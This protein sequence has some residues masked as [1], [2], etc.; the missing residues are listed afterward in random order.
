MNVGGAVV[1]AQEKSDGPVGATVSYALSAAGTVEFSVERKIAGRKVGQTLR[2]EDA[3]PTRPTRNAPLYKKIKGSFSVTGAAGQNSFKFSGRIG[4]K[5]L[6]PGSYRLTGAAGGATKTAASRSS[7]EAS[8]LG[9][10]VLPSR[11]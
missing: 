11:S 7:N 3:K 6:K 8:S 1:S 5:P 2:E 10:V 4:G 9:T